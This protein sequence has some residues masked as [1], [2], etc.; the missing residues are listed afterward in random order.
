MVK[1]KEK[2]EMR[3]CSNVNRVD[4]FSCQTQQRQRP[5][6]QSFF[7]CYTFYFKKIVTVKRECH[8]KVSNVA[9]LRFI[10]TGAHICTFAGAFS[11]PFTGTVFLGNVVEVGRN[12]SRER[13]DFTMIGFIFVGSVLWVTSVIICLCVYVYG[14]LRVMMLLLYDLKKCDLSCLV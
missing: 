5:R 8:E 10:C 9:G 11:H 6:E 12:N 2:K 4:H 13:C 3:N 7:F 14:S 1:I